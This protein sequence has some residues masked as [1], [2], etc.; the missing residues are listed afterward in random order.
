MLP[1]PPAGGAALPV[2]SADRGLSQRGNISQL[3]IVF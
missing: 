3:S 1:L 2:T